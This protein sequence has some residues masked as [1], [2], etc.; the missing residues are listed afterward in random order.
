MFVLIKQFTDTRIYWRQLQRMVDYLMCEHVCFYIYIY[1]FGIDPP[2]IFW[3]INVWVFGLER[4]LIDGWRSTHRTRLYA[5]HK[6][7]FTKCV[8][9]CGWLCPSRGVDE[10]GNLMGSPSPPACTSSCMYAE[11]RC[12][13]T[14]WLFVDLFP[15]WGWVRVVWVLCGLYVSY[16]S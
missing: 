7:A 2:Y 6:K 3:S 12:G 1:L 14:S 11:S 8:C 16:S 10:G 4:Q 5:P 13:E 9:V 15:I